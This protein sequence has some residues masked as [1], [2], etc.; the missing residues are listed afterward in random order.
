M[1]VLYKITRR[2][3]VCLA[4]TEGVPWWRYRQIWLDVEDAN[5]A[6]PQAATYIAQGDKDD[7]YPTLRYLTLCEKALARTACPNTTFGSWSRLAARERRANQ[8]LPMIYWINQ[9]FGLPCQ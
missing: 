9:T 3:L 6:A 7:R 1:G 5:G 2:D 8:I 4:A